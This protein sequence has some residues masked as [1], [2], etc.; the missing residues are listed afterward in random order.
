MKRLIERLVSDESIMDI[1]L[2]DGARR[3]SKK[4]C[5][6]SLVEFYYDEIKK[7]EI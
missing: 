4:R 3:L 2:H 5:K 7:A 1:Y 6:N